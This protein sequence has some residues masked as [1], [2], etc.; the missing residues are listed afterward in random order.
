MPASATREQRRHGRARGRPACRLSR[1]LRRGAATRRVPAW[2]GA[3]ACGPG[4]AVVRARA[5]EAPHG[6]G[7]V[8]YGP[9][10]AACPGRRPSATLRPAPGSASMELLA[11]SRARACGVARGRVIPGAA[12][13]P[14]AGPSRS[15]GGASVST[16]AD[17]PLAAA[18]VAAPGRAVRRSCREPPGHAQLGAPGARVAATSW[19]MG[20][21]AARPPAPAAGSARRRR[22]AIPAGRCSRGAPRR[23]SASRCGPPVSGS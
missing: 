8:R 7:G 16:A 5:A 10:A 20:V 15:I 2:P 21:A 23:R 22:P 17:V 11:E 4:P 12:A 9:W 18:V 3:T 6:R 14:G 1:A 13:R 19:S